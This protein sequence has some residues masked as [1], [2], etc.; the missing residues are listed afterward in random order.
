[1]RC[2]DR[3]LV[4]EMERADWVAI[5]APFGWPDEFLE[6]VNQ[7]AHEGRWPESPLE[8]RARVKQLR[9]R[10]TDLFVEAKARLPLS[11]ST[12]RIAVAAMRCATILPPWGPEGEAFDRTGRHRCAEVY[13]AAAL[14]VWGFDPSGYKRAAGKPKREQLVRELEQRAGWLELS[15]AAREACIHTDHA[16]DAVLCAVLARATERG[17]SWPPPG[18]GSDAQLPAGVEANAEQIRREG[19]IHL[20]RDRETLD[21]LV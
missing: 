14:A 21:R 20:P 17:L 12:D 4:Q 15:D 9:Y 1:L 11:V 16:L 10:V 6:A 2:S 13:P 18:A 8:R 19:W 3:E 5:D 7:W